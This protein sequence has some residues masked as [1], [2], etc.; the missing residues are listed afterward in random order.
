MWRFQV[1]QWDSD[2]RSWLLVWDPV[3]GQLAEIVRVTAGTAI[4]AGLL[5]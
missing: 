2:T 1:I 5:V 4:L 3:V